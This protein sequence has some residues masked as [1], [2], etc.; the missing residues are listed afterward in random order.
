VWEKIKEIYAS[1]FLIATT[2]WLLAHLI[3]IELWGVVQITE[4]NQWILWTEIGMASLI[5]ILAIERFIK[6]L[7]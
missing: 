4:G 1:G 7:R 2:G 6:D 5:L 3:L